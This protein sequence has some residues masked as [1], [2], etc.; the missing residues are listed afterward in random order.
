MKS[1][2]SKTKRECVCDPGAPYYV[3]PFG[4]W[5]S[6]DV[7]YGGY[8]TAKTEKMM[9]Q[10]AKSTPARTRRR[11]HQDTRRAPKSAQVAVKFCCVPL[12]RTGESGSGNA[13][14]LPVLGFCRLPLWPLPPLQPARSRFFKNEAGAQ[15]ARMSATLQQ[16]PKSVTQEGGILER[17]PNQH[18]KSQAR[19]DS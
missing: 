16:A 17:Q 6:R 15:A 7:S 4:V 12:L 1:Q 19:P 3:Y 5:R 9:E 11:P 10:L 13:F 18:Q 14:F 2:S 8:A